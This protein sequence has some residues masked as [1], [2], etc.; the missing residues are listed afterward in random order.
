MAEQTRQ[1]I[2]YEQS[3]I[4]LLVTAVITLVLFLTEVTSH[5]ATAATSIPVL[6]GSVLDVIGITLIT[7]FFFYV[8]GGV[9]LGLQ[10]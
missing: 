2:E 10:F 9:A 4:L 7:L 6:G 1:P 5:M 3:P 8:L